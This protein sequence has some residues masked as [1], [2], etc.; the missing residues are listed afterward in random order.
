MSRSQSWV[1]S[2]GKGTGV[3]FPTSPCLPG[4]SHPPPKGPS[5]A[6]PRWGSHQVWIPR[7]GRGQGGLAL[8][9]Q[10]SDC[11]EK[12]MPGACHIPAETI[13]SN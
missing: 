10:L 2:G 11:Q 4:V 8:A 1:C 13:C 7:G 3:T 12:R 5:V 6:R 9:L